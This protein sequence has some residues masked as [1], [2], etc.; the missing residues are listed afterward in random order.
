MEENSLE[1]KVRGK[2]KPELFDR[3][4]G[5]KTRVFNGLVFPFYGLNFKTDAKKN[6]SE[7][8]KRL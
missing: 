8:G 2:K 1:K 3:I 5:L 4:W 7:N 6:Y